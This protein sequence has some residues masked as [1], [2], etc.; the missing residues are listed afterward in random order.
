M[1]VSEEDRFE[2]LGSPAI[3]GLVPSLSR[4][5]RIQLAPSEAW[6]GAL[7]FELP[8]S[9]DRPLLEVSGVGK[10]NVELPELAD[11]PPRE[12]I[13]GSYIERPPRSLRPMLRDPVMAA[14][15]EAYNHS[16]EIRAVGSD[17]A[18]AIPDAGVRGT[19]QSTPGG[20]YEA[21]LVRGGSQL[22]AKLI[23]TGGGDV[24]I[25]YLSDR[26][27]H[28]VVYGRRGADIP[29]GGADVTVGHDSVEPAS[30][31][32]GDADPVPAPPTGTSRQP[33]NIRFF[34]S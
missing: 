11:V 4:R 17:F 8:E 32:N 2:S 12:A 21:T 9:I 28:Q 1:I 24:L 19:L 25:L 18:I 10:R 7:L 16:L 22:N 26:P 34:G 3:P 30:R 15:Q 27:F 29:D 5:E 31:P 33:G 23:L 14:V 20:H 6:S 13:V